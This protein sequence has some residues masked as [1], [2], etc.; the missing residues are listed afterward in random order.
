MDF[1]SILKLELYNNLVLRIVYSIVA[2]NKLRMPTAE[3]REKC[4]CG[5]H[6]KRYYKRINVEYQSSPVESLKRVSWWKWHR[7][8]WSPTKWAANW[9]GWRSSHP[10]WAGATDADYAKG[11]PVSKKGHCAT[12]GE[13]VPAERDSE[14]VL[15]GKH[16][17]VLLKGNLNLQYRFHLKNKP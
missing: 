16:G 10:E 13:P 11:V 14:P 8:T 9:F 3:C 5:P 1:C 7:T 6:D 2:I 15:E 12:D 17:S 4:R